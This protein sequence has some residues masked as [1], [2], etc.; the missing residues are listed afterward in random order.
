MSRSVCLFSN[1]AN[2]NPRYTYDFIFD[3]WIITKYPYFMVTTK[4]LKLEIFLINL[5]YNKSYPVTDLIQII[6]CYNKHG[7]RVNFMK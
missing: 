4:I 1:M 3:S 6:S 2:T 5:K 7:Q